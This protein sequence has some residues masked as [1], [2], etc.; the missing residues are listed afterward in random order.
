MPRV[1]VS[2]DIDDLT[3]AEGEALVGALCAQFGF[4]FVVVHVNNYVLKNFDIVT[5]PP[6]TRK[7]AKAF[8]KS[9]KQ[10]LAAWHKGH[11]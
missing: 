9:T 5:A 7:L 3:M 6:W 10:A 4:V 8:V 11:R 2:V 1:T